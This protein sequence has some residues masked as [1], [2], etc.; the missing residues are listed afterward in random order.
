MDNSKVYKDMMFCHFTVE[1]S[2]VFESLSI[3]LAGDKEYYLLLATGDVKS[4]S[5]WTPL[6]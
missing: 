2:P 4:K 1:Q 5:F 3:S 6:F